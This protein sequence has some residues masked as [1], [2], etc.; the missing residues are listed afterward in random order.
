MESYEPACGEK[1]FPEGDL[2]ALGEELAGLARNLYAK[3][4]FRRLYSLTEEELEG[5][6]PTIVLT[7]LADEDGGAYFYEYMQQA[8]NFIQV[9]TEDPVRDYLA[10]YECWATDLLAFLRCEISSTCVELRALP[11]LM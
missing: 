10:V 6:R 1:N 7:L 5:R 4:Q 8:C 2:D 9:Q 11:F 3:D